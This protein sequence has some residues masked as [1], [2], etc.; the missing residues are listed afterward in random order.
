MKLQAGEK[1]Q[2]MFSVPYKQG[3]LAKFHL[4]LYSCAL[5]SAPARD[6]DPNARKSIRAVTSI[7]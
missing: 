4:D 7:R 2:V 6:D 3:N 5:D 1:K